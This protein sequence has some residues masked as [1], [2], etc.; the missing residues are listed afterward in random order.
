MCLLVIRQVYVNTQPP[1]LSV[2]NWQ[3]FSGRPQ[4]LHPLPPNC[5]V[6]NFD[7]NIIKIFPQHASD[8]NHNTWIILFIYINMYHTSNIANHLAKHLYIFFSCVCV[9]VICL[10]GIFSPEME[11]YNPGSTKN[12]NKPKIGEITTS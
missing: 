6:D 1:I 8:S 7:E 9:L 4:Y 2:A 5:Q 10:F 12:N 11:F 3:S